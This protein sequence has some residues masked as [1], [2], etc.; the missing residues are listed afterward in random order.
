MSQNCRASQ[1]AKLHIP[2]PQLTPTTPSLPVRH[3]YL[4][5][6]LSGPSRPQTGLPAP[7]LHHILS[8]RLESKAF[9]SLRD[10][11]DR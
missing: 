5:L 7:F 6:G 2:P 4:S 3:Y 8:L 1:F 10:V 11:I 9:P